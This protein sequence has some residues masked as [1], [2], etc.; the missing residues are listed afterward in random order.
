MIHAKTIHLALRHKIQNKTM[1]RLKHSLVFHAKAC[2]VIGIEKASVVYVIGSHPPICQAEGLSFNEFMELLKTCCVSRR[3]VNRLDRLQN[4]GRDLRRSFAQSRQP[5][6]VNL[7]VAIALGDSIAAGFLP[8]GQVAESRDQTLKLQQVEI[9]LRPIS[10]AGE[11]AHVCK[12]RGYSL[13]S[14]GNR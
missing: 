7:F 1:S 11:S 10:P 4:A 5:A 9:L 14:M 6:F 13:G 2:K 8:C 3:S 12:M